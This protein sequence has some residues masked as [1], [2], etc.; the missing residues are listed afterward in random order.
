MLRGT[1]KSLVR[2]AH[3]LELPEAPTILFC[4]KQTTF[5][6]QASQTINDEKRYV[7]PFGPA[8]SR[9]KVIS[10]LLATV[11]SPLLLVH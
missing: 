5:S 9:V 6:T 3:Y 4:C 11:V 10:G 1:L 2:S 8:V 7:A